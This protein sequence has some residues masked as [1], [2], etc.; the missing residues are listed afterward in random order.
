MTPV[1][2]ESKS[3]TRPADA[4]V[5]ALAVPAGLALGVVALVADT[6]PGQLG[7]ILSVAASTGVAW[8]VGAGILG[9][10]CQRLLTAACAG[11][12]IMVLAVLTYYGGNAVV[13]IRPSAGGGY[14]VDKTG[15]WAMVAVVAGPAAGAL[16]WRITHGT[17]LAKSL[18]AG[19]LGGLVVVQ[20]LYAWSPTR[21]YMF[22][23]DATARV[24]ISLLLIAAPLGGALWVSRGLRPAAA[25]GSLVCTSAIGFFL[26]STAQ[27]LHLLRSW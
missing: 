23:G 20:G 15:F 8:G 19:V 11:A 16:G 9:A 26:W 1:P 5:C 10:A 18:A 13:H 4:V 22:G 7:S 14:L 27:S 12:L 24:W 3:P 6:V 17:A 21:S 2:R 25:F